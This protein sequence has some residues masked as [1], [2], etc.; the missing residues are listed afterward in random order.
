MRCGHTA[1][2]LDV[3]AGDTQTNDCYLKIYGCVVKMYLYRPIY[4]IQYTLQFCTC[5][6]VMYVCIMYVRMYMLCIVFVC[7]YVCMNMYVC[8]YV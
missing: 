5:L 7:M 2:V 8:M 4:I 3:V 6:C 1:G